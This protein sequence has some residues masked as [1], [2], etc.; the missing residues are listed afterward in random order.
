MNSTADVATMSVG[1]LPAVFREHLIG[2]QHEPV[3]LL[4][5]AFEINLLHAE[6]IASD[7]RLLFDPDEI[8]LLFDPEEVER[9][10]RADLELQFLKWLASCVLLE[11][12]EEW[13][14]ERT[15]AKESGATTADTG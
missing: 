8:G 6:R 15:P 12:D 9:L 5:H 1:Y 4:L 14:D 11:L 2:Q 10:K 3:R 7:S 13:L